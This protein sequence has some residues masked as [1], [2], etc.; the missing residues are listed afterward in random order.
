MMELLMDDREM[1]KRLI[2][3][4]D[5]YPQLN[6][7]ITHLDVG[8]YHYLLK[9]GRRVIFEYK[10]GADFLKSIR[11]GHL[12]NQVY[13]LATTCDWHFIMVCVG[14]WNQLF[15]ELYYRAGVEYDISDV[16][17][18]IASFNRFTT[19]IVMHSRRDCF[20]MML[21][22]A[23]KIEQDRLLAPK[24]PKKSKNP[25][26]NYLL[27]LHGVSDETVKNIMDAFKPTSLQD[28]LNLTKED[29]VSI[30]GIGTKR[31]EMI[32][33]NIRGET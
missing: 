18:A 17:G 26:V 3:V 1:K 27:G 9:D 32:L 19:V 15:K 20:D 29:L 30:D 16:M 28:L 22:Q 24:T 6:P 31:S 10:T 12:H 25:A 11:D 5:N 23:R 14:S 8:D 33:Q 13:D 21:R 2:W 4:Q 7:S